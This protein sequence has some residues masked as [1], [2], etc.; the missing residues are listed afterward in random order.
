MAQNSSFRDLSDNIN[1]RSAQPTHGTNVLSDQSPGLPN[2]EID[3]AV[4]EL[5]VDETLVVQR[6]L[7]ERVKKNGSG[8]NG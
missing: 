5:V 7:E 4:G 3:P 2:V 6:A 1:V 8:R